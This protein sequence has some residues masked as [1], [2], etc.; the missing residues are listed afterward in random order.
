M[1]RASQHHSPNGR[2]YRISVK[3]EPRG[4]VSR[5]LHDHAFPDFELDAYPPAGEFSLKDGK[6]PVMLVSAG[7]GQT[8]ALSML[9]RALADGRRVV[10]LHAARNAAVHAFRERV[11]A[12][13]T[14]T[15]PLRRAYVYSEPSTGDQPE[16]RGFVTEELLRHYLPTEGTLD[17]YFLGP[18]PF[19]V[20][21]R[22]ALRAIGVPDTRV[23]YEFFGPLEAL[24]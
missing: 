4:L 8:P 15:P 7:V 18:K 14:Q 22:S 11:D 17:V 13:A 19:M 21:V 9:D 5:F 6:G 12:I 1:R 16:H 20:Q 2:S 24:D 3:R 10:Y 23:H